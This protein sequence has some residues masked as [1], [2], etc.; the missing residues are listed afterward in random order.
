MKISLFTL[1]LL[2][3]Q[4]WCIRGQRTIS[5]K[6]STREALSILETLAIVYAVVMARVKRA[7]WLDVS[8][9]SSAYCGVLLIFLECFWNLR[10]FHAGPE[11]VEDDARGACGQITVCEAYS[12]QAL[13]W[14]M[15][16]HGSGLLGMW[17]YW[18][19]DVFCFLWS[20]ALLYPHLLARDMYG[21][22]WFE[23]NSIWH[24]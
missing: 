6:L 2:I 13:K 7:P 3:R 10:S 15:C 24:E 22:V 5:S 23:I 20:V 14:S 12:L 21:K 17:S 8:G 19:C 4:C 16:N 18:F 11:A 9:A 1:S